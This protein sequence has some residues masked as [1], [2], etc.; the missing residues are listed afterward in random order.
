MRSTTEALQAFEATI[1][2]YLVE[3]EN[4]DMEQ[5]LAKPNEE[6]WSIGQMYMHLIQSAQ[7]LQLRNVDQCLAGS[8]AVLG[9]TGEKTDNGRAAFELGSLPPIRIRVPAS[10]QYTPQQP[11]SKKQLIE[12]LH[13]VAE[14][15]K[16]TEIAL[17]QAVEGNTILHPG[18]GALNATEWF[19]L[20]E[21]H[22][23]HHLLQLERL[24]NFQKI[25]NE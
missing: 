24:K 4:L 5:L 2:R 13:S 22:Y 10:P 6:E 12:G 21:M 17:S 8:E 18:L 15:M 20:V 7:F 14:R 19:L 3:L 23:R 11:E 9:S 25:A 16:R 1:E